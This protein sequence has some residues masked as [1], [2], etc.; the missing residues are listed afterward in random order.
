MTPFARIVA[1]SL[2]LVPGVCAAQSA[3]TL[4]VDAAGHPLN[5]DFETG[6]MKDWTASGPA[7]ARAVVE[8]DAV[9]RRRGD[10]K[11]E[12]QGRFWASSFE[13]CG[14][15]G[16]HGT[17]T[18]A[19]FVAS[20]PWASFLI[21]A[22]S[23]PGTKMELVRDDTKAVVFEARGD[24]TENMRRVVA[25]L[26]KVKGVSIFIRLTDDDSAGWGHV[27]FDDFRLHDDKP[28]VPDRPAAS[29]P[30]TYAHSGLSPAEAARAMTAPPGFKVDLIAGEPG[31]GPTD[32][33][34]RR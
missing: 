18:S 13:N 8:G 19:P 31:R 33:A 2:L 11:S 15:D 24:E 7:F 32:R 4:P 34:G 26:A 9:A 23:H 17:L 16:P 12:H 14:G 5:L 28:A 22:G 10:M 29:T 25:D 3:G 27:N 30:D 1:S 6:T 21:G 20:K